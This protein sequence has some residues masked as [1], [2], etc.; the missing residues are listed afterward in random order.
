MQYYSGLQRCV[1]RRVR[2]FGVTYRLHLHDRNVEAKRETSRSWRQA[3]KVK[4][5]TKELFTML[6]SSKLAKSIQKELIVS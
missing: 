3:V 5:K 4:E 1:V 2:R 6:E